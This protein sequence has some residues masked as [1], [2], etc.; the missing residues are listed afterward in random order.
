MY[1]AIVTI[2]V[3]WLHTV[4]LKSNLMII[5]EFPGVNMPANK[6]NLQLGTGR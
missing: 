5:R 3:V 2:N 1:V 6:I 4:W